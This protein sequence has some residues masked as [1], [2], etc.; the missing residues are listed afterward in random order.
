MAHRKIECLF[1]A[2]SMGLMACGDGLIEVD[3]G[4]AALTDAAPT[5]QPA[6]T[7]PTPPAPTGDAAPSVGHS[8]PL[9]CFQGEAFCQGACL[10]ITSNPQHC[11]GCGIVCDSGVCSGGACEGE[12]I[13]EDPS[14]QPTEDEALMCPVGELCDGEC[15][16]TNM[17]NDHCGACGNACMGAMVCVDGGCAAVGEVEGVWVQTNQA[18]AMGADCGVYGQYAPASPLE[19]DPELNE[20]AQAHAM[21]MSLNNFFSHTGSDGSSFVTRI[22]RTDFSGQP[23]GENIAAGQQSPAQAVDG[24]V[25]SDGHCRNLMNPDATKIGIG[26]TTGGPYGTLWVQVFGR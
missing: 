1:L 19:L 14:E 3:Y 2:L 20:A 22:Q 12:P 11:G 16:D 9:T 5:A 24:W 8:G 17:D 23:I 21:D 7:T 4:D 15:V 6:Q 10:D 26:Y 13:A 25:D 18:R